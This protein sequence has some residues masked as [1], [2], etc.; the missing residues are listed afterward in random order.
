MIDLLWGK[1]ALKEK[2]NAWIENERHYGNCFL[3]NGIYVDIKS[4]NDLL[5]DLKEFINNL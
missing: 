2:I 3:K 5:K 4:R 1:K